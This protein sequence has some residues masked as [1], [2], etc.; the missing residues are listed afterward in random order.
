MCSLFIFKFISL[1]AVDRTV[2]KP[3]F[4]LFCPQKA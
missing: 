2:V 3:M 4:M 1:S